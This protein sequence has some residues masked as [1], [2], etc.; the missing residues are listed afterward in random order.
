[1]PVTSLE[2][3]FRGTQLLPWSERHLIYAPGAHAPGYA[4]F[5]SR[6]IC[7]PRWI[8]R[9]AGGLAALLP[10]WL[11]RGDYRLTIYAWDWTDNEV[12]H[13]TRVKLTPDGWRSE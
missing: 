11:A 12:A 3:A 1:V 6:P 13:D 5:A 9:L 8:Y 4:C 2:W 7:A 10:R